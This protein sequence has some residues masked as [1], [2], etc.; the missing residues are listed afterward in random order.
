M[1]PIFLWNPAVAQGSG[2]DDEFNFPYGTQL[3]GSFRDDGIPMSGFGLDGISNTINGVNA[4][5]GALQIYKALN[6]KRTFLGLAPIALPSGVGG[7][8]RR[9]NAVWTNLAAGINA[10]RVIEG[11]EEYDFPSIEVG[12]KHKCDALAHRRK[13]LALEGESVSERG[14]WVWAPERFNGSALE[15]IASGNGLNPPIGYW[16]GIKT[17]PPHSTSIVGRTYYVALMT[18]SIELLPWML[19][20]DSFLVD[21]VVHGSEGVF[22]GELWLSNSPSGGLD[23]LIGTWSGDG[24]FTFN[25]S[26]FTAALGNPAHTTGKLI[27]TTTQARSGLNA[28]DGHYEASMQVRRTY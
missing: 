22:T 7:G 13:A 19:N 23:N 2:D 21:L 6:Y 28:P 3:D 8:L 26:G 24:A 16:A 27:L 5:S 4:S 25:L 18:R 17:Y 11:F 15:L 12:E 9:L 14:S 1:D 10:V 20:Y